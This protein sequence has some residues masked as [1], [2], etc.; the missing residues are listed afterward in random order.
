MEHR[1]H[2][3]HSDVDWASAAESLDLDGEVLGSTLRDVTASLGVLAPSAR[4]I[5]DL[6]CGTGTGTFALAATFP[7]A[8][9]LAVDGS[10]ALLAHL[11][12]R[13][14]GLGIDQR[15]TT[16]QADLD[17]MWPEIG[18]IDVTWAGMSLHHFAD[19]DRVLVDVRRSTRPGGVVAVFEMDGPL[20]FLPD[21][22]LGDVESRC[23]AVSEQQHAAAMPHRGADWAPRLERA[24]FVDVQVH[25][26]VIDLRAP[27]HPLTGR[28][29]QRSLQ[30]LRA[31]VAGRVPADDLAVL[32]SLLAGDA[33]LHREDLNIRG[34]RTLWTGR[35]AG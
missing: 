2:H 20:R 3:G 16:L 25:R 17:Q 5:L 11:Q 14:D 19:P 31:A 33:L 9:I 27:L 34:A 6:G 1:A 12:S 22:G 15:V 13:A 30:G 35:R 21:G 18:P 32:D 23:Y 26:I 7:A 10:A 29:A 24:G 4:R 28:Y 8:H